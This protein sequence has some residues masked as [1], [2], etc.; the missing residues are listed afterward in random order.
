MHLFSAL[1]GRE[2]RMKQISEACAC[3][4]PLFMVPLS[5]KALPLAISLREHHPVKIVAVLMRLCGCR[6]ALSD[7]LAATS[8]CAKRYFLN[9]YVHTTGNRRQPVV[10]G[11][12]SMQ[13]HPCF[14][15]SLRLA[16]V[17][18]RS[19]LVGWLRLTGP[20][21]TLH[22]MC[23]TIDNSIFHIVVGMLTAK[24]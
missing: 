11:L 10:H 17:I 15:N 3:H 8:V 22:S 23:C 20:T 12:R 24:T 4:T 2:S 9:A 18:N 13:L 7:L 1:A 19:A 14:A 21:N 16:Q 6:V 5:P